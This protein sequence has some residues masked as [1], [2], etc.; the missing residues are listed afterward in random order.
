MKEKA[1]EILGERENAKP[2][3]LQERLKRDMGIDV[4]VHAARKAM[5]EEKKDNDD[6]EACFEKLP[7]LFEALKRQNPGTV[8]EIDMEEGRLSM[9]FLCP[10]LVPVH[11][12]IVQ[13]SSPS[14]ALTG[15]RCTKA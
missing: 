4:S 5:S 15:H 2:K 13:Q 1:K 9:A 8:A 12:P 14:T 11:G 3:E 6:E 10:D 7:G